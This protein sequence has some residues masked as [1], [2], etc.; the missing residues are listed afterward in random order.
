MFS[1]SVEWWRMN[2]DENGGVESN[3]S[4]G[5]ISGDNANALSPPDSQRQY[6]VLGL[7]LFWCILYARRRHQIGGVNSVFVDGKNDRGGRRDIVGAQR[8]H[9]VFTIAYRIKK[10][11][12]RHRAVVNIEPRTRTARRAA[13]LA[14][15]AFFRLAR[16]SDVGLPANAVACGAC[17]LTVGNGS[18]RWHV[19]HARTSLPY[20]DLR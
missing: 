9:R 10:R 1:V 8:Y 16:P 12:P 13:E 11:G 18:S 19:G 3:V 7:Y 15:A 6:R 20:R 2:G 17:C 4:S 5:N 14:A